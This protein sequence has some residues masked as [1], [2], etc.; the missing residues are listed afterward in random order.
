MGA[1]NWT[2]WT[3][4]TEDIH[5]A[6]DQLQQEV[7]EEGDYVSPWDAPDDYSPASMEKLLENC[8]DSGTHSILDIEG[9]S[10][11]PVQHED[12]W[13]DQFLTIFPLTRGQLRRIFETTRPTREEIE[14]NE[15]ELAKIELGDWSGRWIIAYEDDKPAYYYIF[16]ASGD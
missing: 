1:S 8:G 6:L 12:T 4:Y 14:E 9:A 15:H 10:R 16:G 13:E 7:F 2:Y 11:E 3:E 5:D